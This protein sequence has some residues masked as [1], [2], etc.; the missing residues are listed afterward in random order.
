MMSLTNLLQ[1]LALFV[2]FLV[3]KTHRGP[4]WWTL[5]T[6]LISSAF[7]FNYLRDSPGIGLFAIVGNNMAFTAGLCFLY[8]GVMRFFDRQEPRAAL[9]TAYAVYNLV[10]VYFTFFNYNWAIRRLLFGIG[11]ATLS[12]FIA[13]VL[14]LEN[15]PS[16]RT[17]RYF[18]AGVFVL[19]MILV[20]ANA[21]NPSA[22]YSGN[23][24]FNSSFLQLAVYLGSLIACTL[25][26]FGF[27]LLVNQRLAV[28]RN[29]TISRLQ[30]ALDQI[31]T[32]TGI[33]PICAHCKKIRGDEGYWEQLEGYM[34]KHTEVE[35]THGICPSCANAH[36]PE[37][38]DVA[39]S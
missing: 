22:R 33:L 17:S 26:T 21:L 16:V 37:F 5:G 18:L 29:E 14:F 3:D 34:S 24:I 12:F 9:S 28:E 39:V 27:I 38:V 31:K 19:E 32:L 8:V 6:A 25:W 15:L 10:I 35:F 1:V 20:S 23:L 13:R 30:L 4:G 11:V 36:F 7:A 2:Q